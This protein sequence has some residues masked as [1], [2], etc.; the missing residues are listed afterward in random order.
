[1]FFGDQAAAFANI[2][3]AI[4]PGGQLVMLV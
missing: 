2:A 3:R 4:R 1:M